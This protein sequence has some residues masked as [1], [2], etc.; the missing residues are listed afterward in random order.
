MTLYLIG[1][2]NAKINLQTF[3]DVVRKSEKIEV[4]NE[5]WKHLVTASE[6]T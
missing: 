1:T 4:G 5:D 2:N 6:Y 3:I